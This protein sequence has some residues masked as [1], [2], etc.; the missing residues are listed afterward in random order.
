MTSSLPA[1]AFDWATRSMSWVASGVSTANFRRN[2]AKLQKVDRA[3]LAP[4]ISNRAKP[5]GFRLIRNRNRCSDRNRFEKIFGHELR[6]ADAAVRSR[7]ARQV[8]SVQPEAGSDLHVIRHR[9]A[10][11]MRA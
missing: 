6:H 1:I 7:I 9:R 10:F 5:S 4:I 8:S 2:K 11:E 3:L